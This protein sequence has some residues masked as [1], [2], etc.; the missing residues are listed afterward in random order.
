MTFTFCE[1]ARTSNVPVGVANPDRLLHLAWATFDQVPRFDPRA[2]KI[3]AQPLR[4]G[5]NQQW[6]VA[7]P[8]DELGNYAGVGRAGQIRFE[9]KNA[10]AVGPVIDNWD[11]SYAQAVDYPSGSIPL[12]A[13]E[14]DG[15]SSTPKALAEVTKNGFPEWYWLLLLLSLILLIIWLL[16]PRR[17]G[18]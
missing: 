5:Y 18:P 10:E 4:T 7:T 2:A 1:P 17:S 15:V 9:F 12:A 6:V 14:Y 13:V 16:L 8:R 3:Q 11:G